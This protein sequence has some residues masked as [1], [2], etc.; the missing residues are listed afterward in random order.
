V[1]YK[2]RTAAAV[3]VNTGVMLTVYETRHSN[4]KKTMKVY[5]L[6]NETC[7]NWP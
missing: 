7:T 6:L 4:D 2:Y 1:I 5:V 3:M